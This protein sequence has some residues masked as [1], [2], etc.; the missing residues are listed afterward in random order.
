MASDPLI[1]DRTQNN[2][3]EAL[4]VS[5]PVMLINLFTP[6]PGLAD[7]FVEVQSAEYVR[8]SGQV[9]GY[10]GNR[11]GKAVDGSGQLVNVA[12]FDSLANYNA[13]RAS[14]LFADHMEIIQP[15]IERAAPGMYSIAY[16]A[17]TV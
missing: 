14:K 3:G 11:L 1:H 13:W 6:K 17:G 12:L 7:K 2:Q 8:L 15:L 16:S 5:G 4:S 10:I 9:E